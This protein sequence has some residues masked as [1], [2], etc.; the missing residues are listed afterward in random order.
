MSWKELVTESSNIDAFGLFYKIIRRKI[1]P[2]T[3]LVQ[4]LES[5]GSIEDALRFQAESMFPRTNKS[6]HCI[7]PTP[8]STLP[9]EPPFSIREV[10]S[11]IKSI[12]NGKAPG[13][14]LLVIE[15]FK[16]SSEEY[17]QKLTSLYNKCLAEGTFPREWKEAVLAIVPKPGKTDMSSIKSYRPISLLCSH[18]KILDKMMTSRLN[19]FIESKKLLS[20]KQ[21]GFRK[22]LSTID[23]I[24]DA[25]SFAKSKWKTCHTLF[26][27]L[28]I[29]QAFD[30][31]KH[32]IICNQLNKINCPVNLH[33]LIQSYLS[34]R[35]VIIKSGE[36]QYI[37]NL[38]QG[39]P[40]GGIISPSLW[41]LSYDSLIKKITK[42]SKGDMPVN[43]V[44]YADD[45]LLQ[46]RGTEVKEMEKLAQ[47]LLQEVFQWGNETGL[48][49]NATKT[50]V[51]LVHKWRSPVKQLDNFL[52][53]IELNY[54]EEIKYCSHFKYL[55]V[56]IDE[57]LSF[58]QHFKY[59]RDKANAVV[60]D[61]C[62]IVKQDWGLNQEKA[63]FLYNACVQPI[64]LYGAEVWGARLQLVKSYKHIIQS[65]Q[66]RMLI[67]ATRAYRT[68][69]TLTLQVITNSPPIWLM[70][71]SRYS[72]RQEVKI[73]LDFEQRT[74]TA[75]FLHPSINPCDILTNDD[76]YETST[77][78]LETTPSY[79]ALGHMAYI[80]WISKD[81]HYI[82]GFSVTF[83]FNT[84]I[85]K[86]MKF[87]SGL[88]INQVSL[89]LTKDMISSLT[90]LEIR[91]LVIHSKDRHL[92]ARLSETDTDI[93]SHELYH[94]LVNIRAK[95]TRVSI[96]PH[97]AP[98]EMTRLSR[99]CQNV[100]LADIAL[101]YNKKTMA[102]FKQKHFKQVIQKWQTI[103]DLGDSGRQ[104]HPPVGRET[105]SWIP[106]V[107]VQSYDFGKEMIQLLTN[108]GSFGQYLKRFKL[109]ANSQC[110]CEDNES[111][112]EHILFE[113]KVY[114]NHNTRQIMSRDSQWKQENIN[115]E[116]VHETMKDLM[117]I[118]AV[119]SRIYH[120]NII[121]EESSR[122][123][124]KK[125]KLTLKV[126]RK[127]QAKTQ[128]TS[129][130]LIKSKDIRSFFK[131]VG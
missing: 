35:S 93:L 112:A 15:M 17:L 3:A 116:L 123:L 7:L 21:K 131:P 49:F 8:I 113:C 80:T 5:T 46:V 4:N 20:N 60:N 85:T 91:S 59:T 19:H 79:E 67:R 57:K 74:P 126:S 58:L 56:I 6:H 100:P 11:A 33:S 61:L 94:S 121:K 95:G 107:G 70:A 83:G 18:G 43:F 1:L 106:T 40:Q 71:L 38:N 64:I 34:N 22:R 130:S 104:G 81:E 69:P 9:N 41:N 27:A 108:H 2:P 37:H 73:S 72:L 51:M 28:D 66:R 24:E 110:Y 50:E 102:W 88:T 44:C 25:I 62:R 92:R 39:N 47:E 89:F 105:Y 45:A 55:G 48:K 32:D 127:T 118:H 16:N 42:K 10:K 75:L 101:G 96:S 14:D 12:A 63:V 120:D 115:N 86:L 23:A 54:Y 97:E 29:S 129:R 117:R 111:T 68:T 26:I 103:W 109:L 84:V 76:T 99:T 13:K 77:P 128:T 31:A 114:E 122:K 65:C 124:K 119:K 90:S 53:P 125:S 36:H 82:A 87:P 78:N 52:F 98:A 30:T